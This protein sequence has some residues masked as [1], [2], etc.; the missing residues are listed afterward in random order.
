[1]RRLVVAALVSPAAAPVLLLVFL[2]ASG[3]RDRG[4][5]LMT[6]IVTAYTYAATA[7]LVVPLVWLFERR[8]WV[9]LWQAALAGV[10]LGA[11]PIFLHAFQL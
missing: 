1:M 8:K 3:S 9:H 11:V 7:T 5:Y 6:L 4:A 2:I 10:L